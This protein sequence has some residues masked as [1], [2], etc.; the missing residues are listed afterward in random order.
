MWTTFLRLR[1]M[2]QRGWMR[3]H[4]KRMHMQLRRLLFG[5]WRWKACKTITIVG[6][7]TTKH[8]HVSFLPTHISKHKG[9]I[10]Y[11]QVMWCLIWN[12]YLAF[13][14]NSSTTTRNTHNKIWLCIAFATLS[15]IYLT[16]IHIYGLICAVVGRYLGIW[17]HGDCH[18][19]WCDDAHDGC[20]F[21]S[22][23]VEEYFAEEANLLD[24]HETELEDAECFE[25]H[26]E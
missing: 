3:A 23:V 9:P 13:T 12:L 20:T 1:L 19:N 11:A 14:S 2:H 25:E 24:A 15:F 21:K 26:V 10:L 7:L 17:L 5:V 8:T 6:C 18:K 16:K 22:E 4:H